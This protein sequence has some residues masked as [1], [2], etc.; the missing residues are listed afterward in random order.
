MPAQIGGSMRRWRNPVS[1]MK[2]GP[3]AGGMNTYS[4]VSAIADNEMAD[5][6]NFDIDLDG[7]LKSRP[8]WTLL[9][10]TSAS[11]TT[12]SLPPDSHQLVLGAFVYEGVQFIIIN[13]C[14]TG[15]Y[16]AYIY[17]VGGP[18]DGTLFKIADGTYSNAIRYDETIYLTPGPEGGSA[19]LGT[20]QSYVLSSG[21]VT[22][23]PNMP[24]GYAACVY[25]DR[26]WISGRRGITPGNSRLFF[27]DLATF[28]TFQSSSFFDIAP[29]DG[30]AVNDLIVYQDNLIIMKDNKTYVLSY[31]QGPPQAVLTK[32]SET[33][34][35]MGRNCVVAYENSIFMLHYNQVYEMTNYTFT[36]VSVKV[37]F[38]YDHTTPFEGQTSTVDE[39]WKFAQSLS[40]VG[41]RLYVRFFNRLYVYHLRLRAWTRYESNDESIQYLGR[42]IRLDNTNT[43]L[44]RGF[45]SYI[46]CS[47]L[48]KV[49]D[50]Q[51]FGTS[52]AWKTYMKIFIMEDRYESLNQETGSLTPF[53]VDIKSSMTTKAYDIGVSQRFKR[54]MHWGIDCITARDVTGTLYPF[55]VNFRV[56]WNQLHTYKWSQ[57]NTWQLPLFSF[58][59]VTVDQSQNAGLV[60]R[61]IR[62]SRSLRFRLLQFKVEMLTSGNTTDGPARLY[63]LTTFVA[64]KEL[65]P[66]AVN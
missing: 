50:P 52:G 11:I 55:S 27:S 65:T 38:E 23:L 59:S 64:V 6:V 37:P 62:F 22:A 28:G 25:K 17:Y 47:A 1:E 44:N 48:G 8:P 10:G 57:L 33:V 63:S 13:S 4:D 12:G 60:R 46:A 5:C 16:A 21:L 32:T 7:S 54:L 31:D 15:T 35:V 51:G 34:G 43:D 14:H 42:A 61:F 24:R 49:T 45:E 19:S 58:P 36:R 40:L 26:L 30:D 9:Y 56:T 29:G 20:G 53:P 41:D 39:W 18:N 66:D 2:I 3:Y